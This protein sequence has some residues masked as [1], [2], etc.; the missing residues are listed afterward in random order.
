[1][2]TS[3]ALKSLIHGVSTDT[4]RLRNKKYLKTQTNM[5]TVENSGL[6]KR[7]PIELT[8]ANTLVNYINDVTN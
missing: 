4:E 5:Q 6:H 7:P 1:M 3:G 2:R 8:A